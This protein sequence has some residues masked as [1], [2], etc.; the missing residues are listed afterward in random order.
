M[1]LVSLMQG[2]KMASAYTMIRHS[3]CNHR[4]GE[5]G[6]YVFPEHHNSKTL[7]R[8]TIAIVD[9]HRDVGG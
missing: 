7:Q 4:L 6:T 2:N 1:Y 3:A 5:V 8:P 9:E